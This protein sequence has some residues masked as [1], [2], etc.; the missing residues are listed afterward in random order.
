MLPVGLSQDDVAR[1]RRD[2][3]VV[4]RGLFS[5]AWVD[6]LASGLA[7]NIAEPGPYRRDY[8][9]DGAPGH[10]FGD[11]CN[12]R[13][14]PEYEDFARNSPAADI[15]GALMGSAKVNLFHEHVL[16]KEPGTSDRTPWHHDQPYY[17]VDGF[18]NVSL[19]L[20]LDPVPK[21]RSVEFIAGSHLWGRWFTPTRFVGVDYE[22]RDDGYEAMPDIEAARD[23]YDIRSFDLAPGDCV[24]FH[25]RTVHG[26]PGN[27]S[28][29]M[30]RRAVAFRWT[31]DDARFALRRGEMSPPF[32]DFPDCTH[33][34]G[35]PLDSPLF[36]VIRG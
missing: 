32:P 3:V 6:K 16:V 5:A 8:T 12:W 17:C 20:P 28:A 21:E 2:G 31:G 30:R 22:R 25:F 23:G 29:D 7:R 19:W 26:A 11:Y 1:Y 10:F 4:L 13:R 35:D 14:I 15:A 33:A 24:A 27:A 9:K 36:P 34:P 18:D